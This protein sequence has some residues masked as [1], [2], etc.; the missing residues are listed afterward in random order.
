M[1]SCCCCIWWHILFCVFRPL[2]SVARDPCRRSFNAL[3]CRLHAT[4]DG[5]FWC[6]LC[7]RRS[8]RLTSGNHLFALHLW[9]SIILINTYNKARF[10]AMCNAT[11]RMCCYGAPQAYRKEFYFFRSPQ[12]RLPILRCVVLPSFVCSNGKCLRCGTVFAL[13]NCLSNV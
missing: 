8:R 7:R 12:G 1:F 10:P 11:Q 3:W 13:R 9:P 6:L 5:W 4:L 2:G